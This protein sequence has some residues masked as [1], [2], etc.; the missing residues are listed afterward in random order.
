MPAPKRRSSSLSPSSG[1]KRSG[2]SRP[3][4]LSASEPDV[5]R[6]RGDVQV[7]GVRQVGEERED[8]P[9][10]DPDEHAL[11]HARRAV[12]GEDVRDQV[13]DR[14]P[15][16]RPLVVAE[17]DPRRVPQQQRDHDRRD[18]RQDQVG[19]PHVAALEAA[20]SHD[21][22]HPQRRGDADQHEHAE[23]VDEQRVPALVPQPRERLVAVDDPDHR[24]HDRRAEHEEAP[25][26]ERVHQPRPEALK[27]LALPEHDRDLVAHARGHLAPALDRA[28]RPDQLR[29][30]RHPAAGDRAAG[31]ERQPERN[32]LGGGDYA[33]L[34]FRS[35]A[36]TAGSTAC[37]SPITP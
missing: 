6:G 36:T 26:D 17:R 8:R 32:R 2:S 37:R 3:R 27:Q 5:D 7:L 10:V 29:Q 33:P 19:L 1:S 24:D 34:A 31:R 12:A 25:E 4:A 16:R 11:E 35:S 22:A 13:R 21:L 18:Q 15:R 30:Q 28:R 9:H 14:R 20:R 23:D